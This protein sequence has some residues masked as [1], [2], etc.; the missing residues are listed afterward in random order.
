MNR[1]IVLS[2]SSLTNCCGV[3]Y[4]KMRWLTLYMYIYICIYLTNSYHLVGLVVSLKI[5]YPEVSAANVGGRA[6]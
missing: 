4:K 2:L 6:A 3:D 5:S 1:D